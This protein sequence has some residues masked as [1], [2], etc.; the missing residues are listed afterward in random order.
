METRIL[1]QI[2]L[3]RNEITVYL[4]LIKLGDTTTGPLIKETGLS[5]SRVYDSLHSLIKKGLVSYYTKNNVKYFKAEDPE[6]LVTSLEEKKEKLQE[7][8][9][10]IKQLKP[11]EKEESYSTIY[12]GFN[13]FKVAFEKIIELCNS[14]DE[15]FTIGFSNPP[16]LKS[17]RL[18]LKQIDKK[19]IK[20]KIPMK[21]LFD[22]E[23]KKTIGKDRE[24]EKYT[25]VKYL[26]K[27]YFSPAAINIFKNYVMIETWEEKPVVIF[28][29]N[30]KIAESFKHYFNLLWGIVK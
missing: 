13:G 29:K 16:N 2:G 26:A 3:T 15:I 30:N 4:T 24:K 10:Q 27:G 1:E 18:F 6:N 25:E 12:E 17:L 22:I 28:I 8:I 5:N 11:K 20:K 14:K 9:P 19:R 7:L 23:M 21:I